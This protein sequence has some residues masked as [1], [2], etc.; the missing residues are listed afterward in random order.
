[1]APQL[2]ETT[3]SDTR[4]A[5]AR[6]VAA[7]A[8]GKVRKKMNLTSLIDAIAVD[9]WLFLPRFLPLLLSS[10]Q[11]YDIC[12]LQ[13]ITV[14]VSVTHESKSNPHKPTPTNSQDAASAAATATTDSAA[15]SSASPAE[16]AAASGKM[17]EFVTALAAQLPVV[18][19]KA[20]A[21]GK[22]GLV[23]KRDREEKARESGLKERSERRLAI[24]QP[25]N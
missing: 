15:S 20:E 14:T 18:F 19:E 25:S 21:K 2:I 10:A 8:A 7:L 22:E 3:E 24:V 5:V 23:G 6:F 9:D 11:I 1:M 4:V 17:A 13:S 12:V 16:A